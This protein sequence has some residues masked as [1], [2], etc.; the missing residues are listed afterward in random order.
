MRAPLEALFIVSM[1]SLVNTAALGHDAHGRSNAPPEARRLKNP[2]ASGVVTL[3]EGKAIYT[4]LCAECHGADGKARTKAAGAMKVRPTDLANYLME[5]M[6]IV[7]ADGD[8]TSFVIKEI[9][10]NQEMPDTLFILK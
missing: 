4:A 1:L 5:S 6:V 8:T 2:V 3:E 10:I 9:K 7:G